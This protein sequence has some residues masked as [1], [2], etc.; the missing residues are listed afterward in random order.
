[1][2]INCE[3]ILNSRATAD[4][5]NALGTGLWRWCIHTSPKT[6]IYQFFDNQSLADLIAG[7]FPESS[8]TASGS[9]HV[10]VR[11]ETSEDPQATIDSLRREL[12][13]TAVEDIL[14]DGL[15]WNG[16]DGGKPLTADDQEQEWWPASRSRNDERNADFR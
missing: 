6:G 3:V 11:D 9:T 5:L 12:P 4:Q 1:M 7:T 16:M 10:W 2:S 14:V 8:W 13:D 15:S